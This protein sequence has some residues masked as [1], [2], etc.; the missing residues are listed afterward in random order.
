MINKR[1]N[2]FIGFIFAFFFF[3]LGMWM[4]PFMKDSVNSSRSNLQC[5]NSSITDGA[6]VTCLE[7]GGGVPYFIIAVLVLVGGFIGK[8]LFFYKE[9]QN[10]S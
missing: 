5:T 1:G 7:V 2:L 9:E 10:E 8:E 3:L 4:L 6:K